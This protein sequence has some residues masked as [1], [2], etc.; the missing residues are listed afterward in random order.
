MPREEFVAWCAYFDIIEEERKIQEQQM[1]YS[2]GN[3]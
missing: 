1:K 2:R 3:L